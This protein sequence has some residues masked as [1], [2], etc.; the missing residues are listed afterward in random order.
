MGDWNPPD[1]S[2]SP[3]WLVPRPNQEDREYWE[4]AGRGELRI[5]HCTSCGRHQ[6]YA[7]MLCSHC[8]KQTLE[9]VTASGAGTVYSFTV[10]R[11]NGVPPFKERLPFVVATVD[12]D[13]DG[14]RLIAAMPELDPADA[15]VGLRVRAAFRP[16]GDA[17]GF[18]DFVAAE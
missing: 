11:Q 12:L 2:E 9:W 8:G 1:W 13:E 15:R 4:G 10:I 16:V 7:R 6:H 5:Q 14:A 3:Q 17:L 18:V